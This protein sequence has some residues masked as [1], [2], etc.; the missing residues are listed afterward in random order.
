[1]EGPLTLPYRLVHLSRFTLNPPSRAIPGGKIQRFVSRSS[2][3]S[4][5]RPVT[6]LALKAE[7][8]ARLQAGDRPWK[9]ETRPQLRRTG[10]DQAGEASGEA[11]HG[12]DLRRLSRKRAAAAAA[13]P[14]PHHRGIR[15]GSARPNGSGFS[16]VFPSGGGPAR[17][18]SAAHENATISHAGF[19]MTSL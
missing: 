4:I 5:V 17:L 11:E 13:A 18:L 2:F 12:C 3:Q 10:R 6:V 1:M 19:L 15:A 8:T 14:G 7:V 9:A 16:L